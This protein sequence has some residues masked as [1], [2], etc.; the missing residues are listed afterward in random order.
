MSWFF[1]AQRFPTGVVLLT[2]TAIVPKPEIFLGPDEQ[3]TVQADG[4]ASSETASCGW[5]SSRQLASVRHRGHLHGE[6]LAR[7]ASPGDGLRR[8]VALARDTVAAEEETAEIPAQG[9]WQG[10]PDRVVRVAAGQWAP[11]SRRAGRQ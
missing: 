9:L 1:R 3:V 5:G 4:S 6:R 10:G 2:G 8:L 7:R 11:I